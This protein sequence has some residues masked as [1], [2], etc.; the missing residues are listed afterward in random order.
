MYIFISGVRITQYVRNNSATTASNNRSV[1]LQDCGR[2]PRSARQCWYVSVIYALYTYRNVFVCMQ[3]AHIA[4]TSQRIRLY[5][6]CKKI[7]LSISR[8]NIFFVCI[9]YKKKL[10]RQRMQ[11]TRIHLQD[12][13]LEFVL[14]LNTLK[15]ITIYFLWYNLVQR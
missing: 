8:S 13:A 3:H 5:A 12:R 7:T 1:L 2:L 14:F 6:T 9:F 15:C 4:N 10:C 11:P